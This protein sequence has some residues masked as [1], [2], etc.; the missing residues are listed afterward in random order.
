MKMKSVFKGKLFDKE[1]RKTF[2]EGFGKINLNKKKRG[3][4][5]FPK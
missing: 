3:K 5:L 2:R 1:S 4:K